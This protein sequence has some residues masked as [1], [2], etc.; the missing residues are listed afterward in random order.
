MVVWRNVCGG[1]DDHAD[2]VERDICLVG[3]NIAREQLELDSNGLTG[4]ARQIKGIENVIRFFVSTPSLAN[5]Q[6]FNVSRQRAVRVE[7]GSGE[8]PVV[9]GK[10]KNIPPIAEPGCDGIG[11]QRND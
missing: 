9:D 8:G 2:V 7:D 4:K 3:N 5:G 11:W 6:D 10:A 1:F